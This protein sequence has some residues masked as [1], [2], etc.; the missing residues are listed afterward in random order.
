MYSRFLILHYDQQAAI[1]S[2]DYCIIKIIFPA[3]C[4]PVILLVR[5]EDGY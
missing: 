4:T 3:V 1:E 2:Y 5:D